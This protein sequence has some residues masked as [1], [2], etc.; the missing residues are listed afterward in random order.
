MLELLMPSPEIHPTF[1]AKFPR[2]PLDAPVVEGLCSELLRRKPPLP[3][4]IRS[5]GATRRLRLVAYQT[6]AIMAYM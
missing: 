5:I 1:I 2:R 4:M 3:A 6:G